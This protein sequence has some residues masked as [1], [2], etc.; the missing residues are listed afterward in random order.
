METRT[1]KLQ[2]QDFSYLCRRKT[3]SGPQDA[4]PR[5]RRQRHRDDRSGAALLR[6]VEA[7]DQR[8]RTLLPEFRFGSQSKVPSIL[9][10]SCWLRRR[11]QPPL[12]VRDTD[13]LKNA[14]LSKLVHDERALKAP[15]HCTQ[16]HHLGSDRAPVRTRRLPRQ[17]RPQRDRRAHVGGGLRRPLV[18]VHPSVRLEDSNSFAP[19]VPQ[20]AEGQSQRR[21]RRLRQSEHAQGSD[22]DPYP[23]EQVLKT[24]V[25]KQA[26]RQRAA[27]KKATQNRPARRPDALPR[28]VYE[29]DPAA[30]TQEALDD[31]AKSIWLERSRQEADGSV[32]TPLWTKNILALSNGDLITVKVDEDIKQQIARI[33]DD[34]A[35][36]ALLQERKGYSKAAADALVPTSAA[37][38]RTTIGT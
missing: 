34:A 17:S 25:K 15:I 26:K 6:L 36:S 37:S 24:I 14:S 35:A 23:S 3:I 10:G 28:D 19:E 9:C 5:R 30:H 32:A 22:G 33:G 1:A 21:A 16:L 4:D 29:L 27:P 12:I 31:I 20:K 11:R 7:S 38:R 13:A 2:A 8:L 18:E